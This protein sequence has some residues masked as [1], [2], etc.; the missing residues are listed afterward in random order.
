[1]AEDNIAIIKLIRDELET[2]D[3]YL[4]FAQ[5]QIQKDR[6]FYKHLLTACGTVLSLMTVAGSIFFYRSV[7]DMRTD[8]KNSMET[9]L[10]LANNRLN[11]EVDRSKFQ[12]DRSLTALDSTMNSRVQQRVASE[13]TPDRINESVDA[14]TRNR[15]DR[16]VSSAIFDTERKLHIETETARV[17][18]LIVSARIQ[19]RDAYDQ[20]LDI[21]FEGAPGSELP[22]LRQRAIREVRSISNQPM[23][24]ELPGYTSEESKL[25]PKFPEG[26]PALSRKA[27][28]DGLRSNNDPVRWYVLKTYSGATPEYTPFLLYVVETEPH[29][30]VLRL[31]LDS[32]ARG[33]NMPTP[34]LVDY[35]SFVKKIQ[36]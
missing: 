23:P 7:S 25:T 28:D 6:T 20:L 13:L 33:A 21:A 31:A 12:V 11:A 30:Q 24:T 1:M 14:Y 26:T 5:E 22:V 27:Y 2:R 34:R 35:R 16:S 36:R 18:N 9:A 3:K 8:I 29:L 15:L 4:T 17:L 32:L 10:S 19:D